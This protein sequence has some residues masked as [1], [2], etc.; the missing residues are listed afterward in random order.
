MFV[1]YDN[2]SGDETPPPKSK[3]IATSQVKETSK[4]PQPAKKKVMLPSAMNFL[5]EIPKSSL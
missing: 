1:D 3:P 2:S 5:N 4:Q